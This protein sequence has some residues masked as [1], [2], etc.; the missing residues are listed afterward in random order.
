[1]LLRAIKVFGDKGRSSQP[2]RSQCFSFVR[3][4]SGPWAGLGKL[5]PIADSLFTV[6]LPPGFASLVLSG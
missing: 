3:S 6:D 4:N 5:H 1:M 2:N